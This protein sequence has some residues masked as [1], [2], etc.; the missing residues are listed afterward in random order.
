[1]KRLILIILLLLSSGPAYA[2]WVLVE[3]N[4]DLVEVMAVYADP[5]TIRRK[6]DLV[7]M[8][9]LTDYTTIQTIAGLSFLSSKAQYEF[10]CAEER[11]RRGSGGHRE[12]GSERRSCCSSRQRSPGQRG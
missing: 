5:D 4:N 7:K 8:W 9:S 1:M 12:R 3:K 11:G 2:E 6:G 10:D